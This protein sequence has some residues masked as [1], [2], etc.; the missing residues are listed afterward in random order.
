MLQSL[1]DKMGGLRRGNRISQA[2]I[3]FVDID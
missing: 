2:E 1:R 3:L